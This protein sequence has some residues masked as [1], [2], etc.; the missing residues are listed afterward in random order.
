V[1]GLSCL[2]CSRSTA[3]LSGAAGC[4]GPGRGGVL[5]GSGVGARPGAGRVASG[6]RHALL[7]EP[8]GRRTTCSSGSAPN[9]FSVAG[10]VR[11]D[12]DGSLGR[13]RPRHAP[14]GF[15]FAPNAVMPGQAG[16]STWRTSISKPDPSRFDVIELRV[17]DHKSRKLITSLAG[18]ARVITRRRRRS[19]RSGASASGFRI[20][21]HVWFRASS[22]E[23]VSRSLP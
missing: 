11:N 22:H 8:R 7:Y 12:R 23:L 2:T 18:W 1:K 20:R 9:R 16:W 5:A 10:V 14:Q 3:S 4:G 17:F 21:S 6:W 19:S 15:G 13:G